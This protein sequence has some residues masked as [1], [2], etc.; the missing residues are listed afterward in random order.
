MPAMLG[1]IEATVKS[2]ALS[3]IRTNIRPGVPMVACHAIRAI[4]LLREQKRAVPVTP[5]RTEA[6]T[7]TIASSAIRTSI[8]LQ[9]PTCA[10]PAARAT[11]RLRGQESAVPATLERTAVRTAPNATNVD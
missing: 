1:D 8:L 5:E 10:H 2:S 9:A 11:I 3:A 4:F 6:T 7:T